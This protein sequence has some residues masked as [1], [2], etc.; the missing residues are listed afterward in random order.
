MFQKHGIIDKEREVG[1][2]AVCAQCA[3]EKFECKIKQRQ[4]VY[5]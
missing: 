3:L 4:R 2:D 1:Q 5:Y